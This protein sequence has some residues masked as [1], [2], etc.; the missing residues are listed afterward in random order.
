ML[1]KLKIQKVFSLTQIPSK[2]GW[3]LI[4]KYGTFKN[5]T[6]WELNS[7]YLTWAKNLRPNEC[8]IQRQL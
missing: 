6:L 4:L 8:K 2:F 1:F 3:V 7:G 5:E